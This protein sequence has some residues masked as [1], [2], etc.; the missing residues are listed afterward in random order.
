[1]ATYAI[2]D[3]QGCYDQLRSLLAQLRFEPARDRLWFCGDL[4]NRG[5]ASSEVL[6]LAR[7][8]GDRVVAVLGNHD[9][10]L[11]A[12]ACGKRPLRTKD[13]FTDVLDA[14]DREALIEWL[15]HLPLLHHDAGLGYT[16]V[17]AGLSPQWDLNT[18]K[19]CAG[20][21]E[22]ALTGEG[23]TQLLE[24]M[25]GDQPDQWSESLTGWDRLRVIINCITRI[26]YCDRR[27]RLALP[28]KGPP[29][30][31]PPGMIPWF[32][33]HERKTRGEAILFGHWATLQ[34]HHQLAP[35]HGV[36]HLD[37]GCA[38]GGHL[39]AMRLEDRQRFCVPCGDS[40]A[41]R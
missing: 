9:L 15:R 5:P 39:T 17:H 1:M 16:L 14:P 37:T 6:R 31:Q 23:W 35:S 32:A 19:R 8:L 13:T 24:R 18:A 11:L 22:Q 12:A 25:Y 36:Y 21:V 2:G 34:I 29:G 40:A 26:R 3:V 38:W 4:V 28:E 7:G 33:V 30:S 20:E 27:G 41:A 10:H